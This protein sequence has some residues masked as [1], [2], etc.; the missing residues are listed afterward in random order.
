[1][2]TRDT[3]NTVTR[4]RFLAAAGA[5]TGSATLGIGGRSLNWS[6]T[7]LVE[8]NVGYAATDGLDAALSEATEIVREFDFDAVTLRLPRGAAGWLAGHDDVRYVEHNIQKRLLEGVETQDV[9]PQSDT[10]PNGIERIDCDLVHEAGFTGKGASVAVVDTGIESTHEDLEQNLGAGKSY[11]E[12]EEEEVIVDEDEDGTTVIIRDGDVEDS[13]LPAWQ[14]GHGHGTHV[15][16]IAA[17][18]DNG[19][20]IVGVAPEATLHAVKIGTEDGIDASDVAAGIEHVGDQGWDVANVSLGDEEQS[21]VIKDACRYAYEK[22]VLLVG[23]AGNA[24][25]GEDN[26][27]VRYPAANEEVVAVSATTGDGEIAEFSLTGPEV[28]LA[29]P[30]EEILSTIPGDD[31]Q[32]SSGTSMAAPHVCGAAALLMADGYSNVEARARLCETAEDVGLDETEQG[33]GVVN[34]AAALGVG[35]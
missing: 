25:E 7:E 13:N 31:Y 30:G 12:E 15:A 26:T 20:G 35:T 22:G 27:I 16:G 34:V 11:V 10:L 23:A 8:V 24:D 6:A 32:E 18:A 29:A 2:T 1:M 17:A 4:R 33:Y 3:S 14:D 9:Q 28:E 5:V 19:E 21:D